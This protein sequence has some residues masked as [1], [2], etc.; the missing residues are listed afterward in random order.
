[1]SNRAPT[2]AEVLRLALERSSRALRVGL[3]GRVERFDAANQLADVTPLLQES[4]TDESGNEQLESLPVL[5]NV[6][7]QFA[8]GGGFAETFPVAAGD[9]CWITFS[10]RSL[11]EW[12]DR[13]GVVDPVD[14]RR[15][16]LGDP[17]AILGVRAKPGKLTEFDTARAVFGNKGPRIAV[18]GS[19][20]HLGVAHNAN[21]GQAVLRGDAY[22]SGEDTMIDAIDTAIASAAASLIAATAALTSAAAANAVPIVGGIPAAPL[23]VTAATALTSAATAL[24]AVKPAVTAFKAQASSYVSSEVKVP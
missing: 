2:L 5:T 6:P 21:A 19:I 11:D 7:V 3:P 14:A 18:D 20:V 13:G 12:I 15:H 17:V 1:M 9:P 23:F 4:A 10:D 8:G 22:R 16:D 24:Q